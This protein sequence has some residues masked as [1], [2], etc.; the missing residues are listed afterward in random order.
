MRRW[1][2]LL[3]VVLVAVAGCGG[4]DRPAG[5]TQPRPGPSTTATAV[6][7]RCDEADVGATPIRFRTSDGVTLTGAVVGSGPVGAVLIHEYPLDYCG[8]LPYAGYLAH[9]GVRA[10]AF[11]LRCFGGSAC[12]AGRGHAL[13]DVAAAMEELRG[14]G[15][16]SVALVGASMGGSVAVVAAARLHPAAV[17]DLSGERDTTSLTPGV[18]ANAGAAAPGVT[19][20]ALFVVARE[21]QYTPVSDMRAVARRAGSTT[22]R[23]I[24]LPAEAGHGWAMLPGITSEWSPLA[25]TVA[26]F[27]RRHTG[28]ES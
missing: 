22:K 10:L 13:T 28:A 7:A 19:A 23:T 20:P 1:I 9:H 8:W 16:R 26:S 3:A 24:V 21:D 12:P 25:R 4:T 11:D 6:K 17:V 27:I 14:R 5:D 15:A 18:D 2:G